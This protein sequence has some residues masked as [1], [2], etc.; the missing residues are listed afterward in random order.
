MHELR[1]DQDSMTI[2]AILNP[3][4]R[5]SSAIHCRLFQ[6]PIL[7]SLFLL[8]VFIIS[9]HKLAPPQPP[10]NFVDTTSHNISW[11]IYQF[12]D[13]LSNALFDVG[14]VND[15]LAYAVGS[16][17]LNDSTGHLTFP[18]YG[19]VRWNGK[20]WKLLQLSWV[21]N[22]GNKS[23][24]DNIEGILILSPND[25]W[26]A[27]GSVFHWDGVSPQAQLMWLRNAVPDPDAFIIRL[28]GNSPSSIYAVGNAGTIIHYDGKTW[29]A[30]KS[31]TTMQ[32]RDIWGAVD[33]SNGTTQILAVASADSAKKLIRIQGTSASFIPD[34]G[35]ST[36]LS[37]VWFV[38]NQKYYVVGAGIGQKDR[39]DNSP[40]SVYPS[41]VV[42]SYM[43]S[44]VRGRAINDVFVVG[45]FRELVHFNGES[46]HNYRDQVPITNGALG[47]IAMTEHL[48]IAVGD[49][50]QPA[51]AVVG[52]R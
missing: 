41:G 2:T 32:I 6:V 28:W 16:I 35:L 25:I 42:T 15:T 12:G 8:S 37:S 24:F 27:A 18:G 1:F 51:I 19:I 38:P 43:S 34:S 14:I 9:C 26:L 7:C 11:S 46:W 30:I 47:Q 49:D 5:T 36:A 13:A 22:E 29:Q 31:G 20:T 21:D 44:R 4:E 52:R 39:L 40:W 33:P 45:S 3:K 23:Y 50:G 10:D 48:V 17:T